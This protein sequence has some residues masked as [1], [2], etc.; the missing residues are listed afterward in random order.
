VRLIT[1]YPRYLGVCPSASPLASLPQPVLPTPSKATQNAP[2]SHSPSLYCKCDPTSRWFLAR[3]I[4][5]GKLGVEHEPVA[6]ENELD[7]D[8]NFYYYYGNRAG[9]MSGEGEILRE[10]TRGVRG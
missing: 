2:S 8:F 6:E 10:E 1:G 4:R 9:W 7:V 3:D 5:C